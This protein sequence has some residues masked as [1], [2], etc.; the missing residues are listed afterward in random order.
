MVSLYFR[1]G[2]RSYFSSL[3][4]WGIS[5]LNKFNGMWSFAIHDV[6]KD[7]VLFSRDRFGIK[8]FYYKENIINLSLVQK[9]AAFK[10]DKPNLLNENILLESMLTHIDNHTDETYF[11]GILVCHHRAI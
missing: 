2:Y 3:R 4:F 6:E 11:K 5:C 1:V 9:S 7:I 10:F 8:P